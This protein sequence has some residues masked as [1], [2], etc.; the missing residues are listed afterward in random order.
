[1]IYPIYTYG[2]EILRKK[3]EDV[4]LNDPNICDPTLPTLISDMFETMHNANGVGLA[5]PQIGVSKRIVVVEEEVSEGV[6]FKGVFINPKI[7]NYGGY[8]TSITEGCLSFPD[9]KIQVQ[10]SSFV[11]V[12]WYD[13]NKEYHRELLYNIP[14]IIIQH[15]VDHL[16][17][18][19]FI[20]KLNADDRL[21]TFIKLEDIK[22]KKVKANYEIK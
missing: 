1:M 12:E 2:E 6:V 16:N 18:V 17:G 4:D 20:D 9:L 21:K 19:V 8:M 13:G 3:A 22:N 11:D 5:A 15:E 14:A 7:I 10:R